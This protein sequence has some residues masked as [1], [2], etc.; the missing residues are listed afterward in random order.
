[1]GWVS[2]LAE[3]VNQLKFFEII[4]EYQSGLYFR[5]GTVIKR[6]IKLSEEEKRNI[7]AEEKELIK[8]LGWNSFLPFRKPKLP[9]G[10]RRSKIL[11]LPLHPKRYEK[12]KTLRPGFY[13]H[14]PIL[15][16]IAMENIKPKVLDLD[17]VSV[18]VKNNGTYLD[19]GSILTKRDTN[20]DGRILLSCNILY[21]V[22]DVYKAVTQ[23]DEYEKSLKTYAISL[24]AKHAR[25]KNSDELRDKE[26]IEELER[27]VIDELRD[28]ATAKWGLKIHELHITDNVSH[29]VQRLFHQGQPILPSAEIEG[30]EQ[31][32]STE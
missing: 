28:T 30:T 15:E 1:M 23:V 32:G 5:K 19:S 2:E 13:F 9:E 25:G 10:Y 11:G 12:S 24:L 26:K 22:L 29:T 4:D 18:P 6:S 21:R 17:N 3:I 31:N 27:K 20:K 16:Y 8:K 7:K 14:F